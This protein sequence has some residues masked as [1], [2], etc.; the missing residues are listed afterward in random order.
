MDT[1]AQRLFKTGR[2]FSGTNEP[3]DKCGYCHYGPNINLDI[4][5]QDGAVLCVSCWNETYS[6]SDEDKI[7]EAWLADYYGIDLPI[8]PTT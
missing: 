2:R 1:Q 4:I 8:N 7:T 5:G 3:C 6:F